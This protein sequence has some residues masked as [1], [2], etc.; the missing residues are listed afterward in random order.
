[1]DLISNLSLHRVGSPFDRRVTAL[2]WHPF[3]PNI[4]GVGSKGGDIILWDTEQVN[5]DDRFV[6]GVSWVSFS[7]KWEIKFLNF[8][9]VKQKF[10]DVYNIFPK[11]S[12]K[13]KFR[14]NTPHP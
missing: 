6:T 14:Q 11:N 3:K 13:C 9:T 10:Y 2:E 12:A 5:Q 1:M 4:L 7:E 8:L